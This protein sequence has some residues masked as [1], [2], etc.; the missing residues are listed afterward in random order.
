[1]ETLFLDPEMQ[2]VPQRIRA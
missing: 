1:M 2:T